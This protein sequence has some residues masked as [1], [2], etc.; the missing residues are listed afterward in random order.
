M[1][2]SF[3]QYHGKPRPVILKRRRYG[4]MP[5]AG[6][7]R[8]IIKQLEQAA[9]AEGLPPLSFKF[10]PAEVAAIYTH[11]HGEGEGV[12]FRLKSG[13]I[14]NQHGEP[15]GTDTAPFTEDQDLSG[16]LAGT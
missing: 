3:W 10:S 6:E 5:E 8:A 9:T 1:T 15:E 12:W 14:I 13:Q 2:R 11:M 4:A 7:A 16:K